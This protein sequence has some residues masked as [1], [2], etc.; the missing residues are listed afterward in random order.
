MIVADANTLAY[1]W[2]PSLYSEE[3]EA[4]LT[5]ERQWAAPFLWRSEFRSILAKY[6][7]ANYYS[8]SQISDFSQ[9]TQAQQ[10]GMWGTTLYFQPWLRF[11]GL[12]VSAAD[13]FHHGLNKPL[14]LT[15]RSARKPL[16]IKH[17]P[18]LHSTK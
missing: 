1:V 10:L 12:Y 8:F 16:L 13:G 9:N 2:L 14:H 6:L 15:G 3:V 18:H 4:L 17:L 11:A 7:K 5:N